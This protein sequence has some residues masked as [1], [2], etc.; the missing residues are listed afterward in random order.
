MVIAY[1][2]AAVVFVSCSGVN[3]PTNMA[4]KLSTIFEEHRNWGDND[5]A[6]DSFKNKMI[7]FFNDATNKE[8]ISFYDGEVS[9]DEIVQTEN[10]HI[11]TTDSVV[12][13]F[14]CLDHV[15]IENT[16]GGHDSFTVEFGVVGKMHKSEATNLERD[17]KYYLNGNIFGYL[18]DISVDRVVHTIN[19]GLI[20]CDALKLMPC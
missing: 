14:K 13:K 2:M 7:T 10:R 3:K 16:K 11:N 6:F 20:L 4:T 12:V 5:L 18:E 1:F 9:F 15:Y 19:M 17:I 8:F